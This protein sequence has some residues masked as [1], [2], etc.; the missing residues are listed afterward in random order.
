MGIREGNTLK[1]L[2]NASSHGGVL[3][4]GEKMNR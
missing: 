4:G 3:F 2:N 1:I